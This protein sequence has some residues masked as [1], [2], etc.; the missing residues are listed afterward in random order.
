MLEFDVQAACDA[1]GLVAVTRR[2]ASIETRRK[3]QADAIGRTEVEIVADH[4][5]EAPATVD[6]HGHLYFVNRFE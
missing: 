1:I 6:R 2:R 3:R 5:F 4:R